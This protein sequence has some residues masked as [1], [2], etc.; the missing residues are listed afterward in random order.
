MQDLINTA[1]LVEDWGPQPS[2]YDPFN[3]VIGSIASSDW[4]LADWAGS[5]QYCPVSALLG[6]SP[7]TTSSKFDPVSGIAEW[8]APSRVTSGVN[9]FDMVAVLLTADVRAPAKALDGSDLWDPVAAVL[10]AAAGWTPPRP[11]S[12]VE[13]DKYDPFPAAVDA[14]K[15]AKAPRLGDG[16]ARWDPVAWLL[17]GWGG[18]WGEPS[19]S[20]TYDPVLALRHAEAPTS[21]SKFDLAQAVFQSEAPQGPSEGTGTVVIEKKPENR[22]FWEWRRSKAPLEE[23]EEA[24]VE[25]RVPQS[26]TYGW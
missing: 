10:D 3:G 9:K 15:D 18:E 24:K 26:A 23:E 25:V 2:R 13:G 1:L 6:A 16:G 21:R 7:S 14:V 8:K 17:A 19:S 11:R 4:D 5:S 22:S 12:L 20:E